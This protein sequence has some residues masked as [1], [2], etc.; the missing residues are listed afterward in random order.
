MQGDRPPRRSR[1]PPPCLLGPR[2][3]RRIRSCHRKAADL[4]IFWLDLHEGILNVSDREHRG[5]TAYAPDGGGEL[6]HTPTRGGAL[7]GW[8]EDDAA[9]V[10]IARR[11]VQRLSKATGAI[12]ATY[13]CDSAVHSCATSPSG[14]RSIP[15]CD[16]G[17]RC[18]LCRGRPAP[19]GRRLLPGPR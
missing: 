1:Q 2:L 13:A 17:A 10:G 14:R 18:A 19:G 3:R 9:Y 16:T 15:K 4:D 7:F 6:W 11:V 5:V 12:E 8:Q